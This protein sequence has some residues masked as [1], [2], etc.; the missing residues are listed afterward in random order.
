[1]IRSLH[2]ATYETR[3]EDM[4]NIAGIPVFEIEFD[5]AGKLGSHQRSLPNC[6]LS[7]ARSK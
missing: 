1:M 3:H 5:K 2:I 6:P 4:K 7:W